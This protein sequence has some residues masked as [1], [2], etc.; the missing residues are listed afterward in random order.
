MVKTRGR[1][2]RAKPAKY[3]HGKKLTAEEWQDVKIANIAGAEDRI[4]AAKY[5][6]PVGT[7]R[8]RRCLDKLW[9]AAI[10]TQKKVIVSKPVETPSRLIAQESIYES[11][12]SLSETNRLLALR[13]AGK[14]LAAALDKRGELRNHLKPNEIK[15]LKD[16]TD[17]AAKAGSWAS[18]QAV[19]VN[20]QAFAGVAVSTSGGAGQDNSQIIDVE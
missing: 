10:Q 12:S 3:K 9:A 15:D 19:T 1:K 7:L 8:T 6:I 2:P 11:A 20:C 14:G 4:L 13:I 18:E 17:I 16:L 5:G